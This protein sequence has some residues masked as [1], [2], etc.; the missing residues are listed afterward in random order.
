MGNNVKSLSIVRFDITDW[1]MGHDIDTM[2]GNMHSTTE[3]DSRGNIV[4]ET[5]YAHDGTVEHM[6][7][8]VYSESGKLER[9]NQ[10][11]DG[12]ELSEWKLFS[13]NENG[14]LEA[15]Y[16][17]YLD[18]SIDTVEYS[19]NEDG[20][21]V[22]KKYA[23]S[24]GEIEK[25]EQYSYENQKLIKEEVFDFDGNLTACDTYSYTEAG[26]IEESSHESFTDGPYSRLVHKYNEKG[27]RIKSLAYNDKDQLIEITRYQL[28]DENRVTEIEDEDQKRKNRT[29][30]QY[31]DRGNVLS[32]IESD[33]DEEV[34]SR[35]ERSYDEQNMI[36]Q[37]KVFMSGQGYRP[38]QNYVLKYDYTYFENA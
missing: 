32:Q 23:N 9:L 31:D 26:I 38:D 29:V 33:K 2:D 35:V 24:E 36:L 18:G 11:L 30:L 28:D 16:I 8:Y 14:S 13:W 10:Y 17:H 27:Y 15:E 3:Y 6:T 4:K 7:E 20:K 12:E 34:L 25:H 22:E 21:I 37:S 19:Y 5:D 1:E